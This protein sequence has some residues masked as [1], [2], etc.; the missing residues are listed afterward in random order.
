GYRKLATIIYL[1]TSGSLDK[2]Y[3][4]F[5]DEPET[6]MNPMMIKYIVEAVAE[7]AKMGVQVFITTHDYFVQQCF[8][9]ISAYPKM[10]EGNLDIQFVSLYR[11]EE[12]KIRYST[13]RQVSEL[14]Q[15]SI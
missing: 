4:L 15:N 11:N 2:N 3:V 10:N 13:A 1:I 8:N 5:W 9:L 14:E 7:L 6:N 12:G